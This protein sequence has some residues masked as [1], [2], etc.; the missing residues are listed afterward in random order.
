MVRL[1]SRSSRGQKSKTAGQV[2]EGDGGGGG[3]GIAGRNAKVADTRKS[4]RWATRNGPPEVTLCALRHRRRDAVCRCGGSLLHLQLS[5]LCSGGTDDVTQQAA[6]ALTG[7]LK[8]SR[9]TQAGKLPS[10]EGGRA[11]IWVGQQRSSRLQWQPP[12]CRLA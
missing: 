8:R 11:A 2:G 1:P 12:T 3:W 10:T 7:S 9:L 4:E 6:Q 5:Q